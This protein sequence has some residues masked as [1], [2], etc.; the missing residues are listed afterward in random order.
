MGEAS[1]EKGTAGGKEAAVGQM[2][3]RQSAAP[4]GGGEGIILGD[5]GRTKD[6]KWSKEK[7]AALK[8]GRTDANAPDPALRSAEKSLAVDRVGKRTMASKDE[9]GAFRPMPL[10]ME[11]R[12]QMSATRSGGSRSVTALKKCF[13][14]RRT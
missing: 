6:S 4:A 13:F 10:G 7:A 9:P 5:R 14:R 2:S 3:E 12:G 1:Q 11:G 8:A